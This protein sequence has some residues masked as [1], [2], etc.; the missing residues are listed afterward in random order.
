[1]KSNTKIVSKFKKQNEKQ[2]Y[3]RI[4]C[5]E[6]LCAMDCLMHH[7]SE[8]SDRDQGGSQALEDWMF[9]AVPNNDKWKLMRTDKTRK[10]FYYKI[11][12]DITPSTFEMIVML[13]ANFVKDKCFDVRYNPGAFL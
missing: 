4:S 6:V 7:L 12:K 11:V 9:S 2:E 8:R 10:S 1:M 3:K 13:F 5:A